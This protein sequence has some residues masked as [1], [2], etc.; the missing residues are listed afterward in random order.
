M[1][2]CVPQEALRNLDTAFAHVL[3][4]CQLKRQG[5]LWRKVGYPQVKTKQRGLGSFR[6]TLTIVVFADSIQLP[7]LGRLRLRGAGL[8]PGGRHQRG[9]GPLGQGCLNRPDAGT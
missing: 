7:R 5:K 2:K 1:A 9:Q 8:S 6:L 3:R 4:R